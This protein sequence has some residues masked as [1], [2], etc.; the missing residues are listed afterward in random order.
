MVNQVR[1]LINVDSKKLKTLCPFFGISESLCK[2]GCGYINKE[3]AKNILKKCL[4]YYDSCST[5][6]ELTGSSN[7]VTFFSLKSK[8][9]DLMRNF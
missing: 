8:I 6:L 5:Y 9:F 4:N 2:T 7:S 1:E 3:E